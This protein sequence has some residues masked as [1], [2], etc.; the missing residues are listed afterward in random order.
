MTRAIDWTE[1]EF[2][3]LLDSATGSDAELAERFPLRSPG[4]VGVVRAGVHDYHTGGRS[5]LLSRVM[6]RMLERQRRR[7]TCAMC[8]EQ[9]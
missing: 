5:G 8:H 4:A 2:A 6:L 1:Q 3:I 7:R 9:F